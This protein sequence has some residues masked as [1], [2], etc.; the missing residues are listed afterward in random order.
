MAGQRARGVCAIVVT[1]LPDT[2]L[3]AKVIHETSRQVGRVVVVDNGSGPGVVEAAANGCDAGSIEI[4]RLGR[5]CGVGAAHNAGIQA[6]RKQGFRRVLILDQDSIPQASMVQRLSEALGSL[7][8]RGVRVC[9]VGPKYRDPVTQHESYFVR[10]G[11]WKFKRSYCEGEAPGRI[12]S[13]DF[14]ISSGSLIP[15]AVLDEVG[16][17]DENLFIDHV[18][19]DWYLRARSLGYKAFGV[20]QAVMQHSLGTRTIRVRGLREH[21][22]AL[23][24]PLRLYYLVRNSLLLY[25]RRHVPPG[26]WVADGKRLLSLCVFFGMLVPPR[27]KNLRMMLKG[28]WHG[29][30]GVSG[31]YDD[32]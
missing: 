16:G 12:V 13:A 1:Y 11:G 29:L 5:N 10:L 7:E 2:S 23:R 8:E 28:A 25:R 19:T 21:R 26:M 3:L 15:M 14:L 22:V 27:L 24:P 17:M 30:T 31:R 18:D 6:A 9:A 4:L 20:C 32:R